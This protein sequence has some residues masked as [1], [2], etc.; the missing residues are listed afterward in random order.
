GLALSRCFAQDGIDL[1]MVARD[2]ARLN[3]AADNIKKQYAIEVTTIAMDLTDHSAP[4]K[5][6]S[7][8]TSRGITVNYLVNNAGVGSHGCFAKSDPDANSAMIDLNVSAL[9][10]LTR[11][12]IAP[13]LSSN[14]GRIL[15]VASLVGY[16][17]GGP[18]AALYYATKSFVLSF[19]RGLAKELKA[20]NV[21][22]TALC[23]GP[24]H[25]NFQSQNGFSET[26]LYHLFNSPP[27]QVARAGYR[28]M[29]RGK[30]SV[31]PGFINKLLAFGGELPPRQIA[32]A[33]NSWLLTKVA[34][35]KAINATKPQGAEK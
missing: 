24:T 27:Q 2:A 7:D 14:G 17:P 19:T 23:P 15:N 3:E 22:V 20:S 35:K 25:T 32:L 1:I 33:I 13:M 21:T 30:V 34:A 29:Q 28:A 12:F 6:Y 18:Q 31:I 9:T 26:R 16:Q 5:L 11:L 10:A 4:E 8:I